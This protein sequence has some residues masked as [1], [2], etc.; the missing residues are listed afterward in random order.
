[1]GPKKAFV[2]KSYF[3]YA[4]Y[5]L[6][7]IW[8]LNDEAKKSANGTFDKN[9]LTYKLMIRQPDFVSAEFATKIIEQVKKSKP[10]PLL[11]EICFEEIDDGLCIQMLHTGSYDSEPA[12][13]EQ[14]MEFAT[15]NNCI[16]TTRTHREIYL[17]DAR[18]VAAEKLKTVLRINVEKK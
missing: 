17:S 9:D 2:S 12:S 14:M 16:R 5:P 15:K 11:N 1:M 3:D 10:H 4:V 8:D 18:K 6:E 13:F 7:G